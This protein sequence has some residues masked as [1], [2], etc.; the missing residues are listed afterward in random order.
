MVVV[1]L[2]LIVLREIHEVARLE[3]PNVL[4]L[5]PPDVYHRLIINKKYN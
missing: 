4:S 3:F 2:H 5:G 1:V